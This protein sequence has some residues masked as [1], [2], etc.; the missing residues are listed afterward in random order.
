[1]KSNG[2]GMEETWTRKIQYYKNIMLCISIGYVYI[3]TIGCECGKMS[4]N[5]EMGAFVKTRRGNKTRVYSIF[6]IGMKWFKKCYFSK[7]DR[8][9]VS[10][11]LIYDT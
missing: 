6:Q 2:L 7:E 10:D 3:M 1:M 8:K 4:R 5:K 9:L 11:F